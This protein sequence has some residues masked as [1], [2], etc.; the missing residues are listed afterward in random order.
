MRETNEYFKGIL[1]KILDS[2]S[3]IENLTDNPSYLQVLKIEMAK[4][5]GF[6][7]IIHRKLRIMD[8]K[9][10]EFSTLEKIVAEYIKNYDFSR[11]IDLLLK[12]Y[13]ED[14]SRVKNIRISILKSLNDNKLIEKMYD[15]SKKL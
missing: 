3:I 11:E 2:Y 10:S 1:N 7:T 4:T 6:F 8:N 14:I 5:M 15:I 9:S 12:T 13:S